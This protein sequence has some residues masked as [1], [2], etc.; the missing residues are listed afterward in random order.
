MPETFSIFHIITM[1][2]HKQEINAETLPATA[3]LFLS[4]CVRC[5]FCS[6][7][8]TRN[9][10]QSLPFFKFQK[11]WLFS[12]AVEKLLSFSFDFRVLIFFTSHVLQLVSIC[13]LLTHDYIK[14]CILSR[15]LAVV[16]LRPLP[17]L[18]S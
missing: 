9:P 14:F 18:L 6:L 12:Y 4:G 15:K 2:N 7:C 11:H 17:C 5:F 1:S 3:L 8:D 13:L 16:F 10:R